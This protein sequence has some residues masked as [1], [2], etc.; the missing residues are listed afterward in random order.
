[1]AHFLRHLAKLLSDLSA[2]VFGEAAHRPGGANAVK[3]PNRSDLHRSRNRRY[4]QFDFLNAFG[5]A[6]AEDVIKLA[7]QALRITARIFGKGAQR[8][9]SDI[10]SKRIIRKG[11]DDF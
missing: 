6:A 9:R 8:A 5:I 3:R 4:P 2:A 11:C 10:L 7:R 1:M